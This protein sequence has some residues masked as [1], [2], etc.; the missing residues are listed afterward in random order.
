[1]SRNEGISAEKKKKLPPP[2]KPKV[3]E[4]MSTPAEANEEPTTTPGEE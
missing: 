3:F 4:T 2:K 1:M